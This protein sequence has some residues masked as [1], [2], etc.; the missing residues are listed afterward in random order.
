MV[1]GYGKVV[2]VPLAFSVF[3]MFHLMFKDGVAVLPFGF[4]EEVHD[5]LRELAAGIDAA[6]LVGEQ[7]QAHLLKGFPKTGGRHLLQQLSGRVGVVVSVGVDVF[8]E[9]VGLAPAGRAQLGAHVPATLENIYLTVGMFQ[10]FLRQEEAGGSGTDD[11]D[12]GHSGLSIRKCLTDCWN[13][14]KRS[15]PE[16]MISPPK[17]QLLPPEKSET[18]P[19]ACWMMKAPAATS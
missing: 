16:A 17:S 11:G 3:Q 7:R 12:A 1:K 10:Q 9:K 2:N 14:G 5:G 19:P 6:L 4:P 8:V 15:G 18:W 13:S